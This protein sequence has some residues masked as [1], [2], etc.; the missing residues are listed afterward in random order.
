MEELPGIAL[1]KSPAQSISADVI[2]LRLNLD[3][4]SPQRTTALVKF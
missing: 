2:P 4:P 3:H 1:L